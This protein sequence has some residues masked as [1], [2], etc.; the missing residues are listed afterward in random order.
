MERCVSY[1]SVVLFPR[2]EEVRL[3][4]RSPP[5]CVIWVTERARSGG[6]AGDLGPVSH[7]Q[8]PYLNLLL[9]GGSTGDRFCPIVSCTGL[10]P[11]RV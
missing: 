10:S 11:H 1:L 9:Q 6:Q 5:Q 2:G 7:R 4:Y 8:S 3:T